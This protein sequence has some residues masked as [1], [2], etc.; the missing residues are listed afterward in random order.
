MYQKSRYLEVNKRDKEY[1]V[2][3]R[4]FG[5]L[6]KL[7][8]NAYQML[9]MAAE[10][11]LDIPDFEGI[12]NKF[13]DNYFLVEDKEEEEILKEEIANRKQAQD[14]R[15]LVGLQLIVSN[16]C[17]FHCTY[18]F[19][20]EEHKLRDNSEA[21]RPSDMNFEVARQSVD[22]MIENLKKNNNKLLSI[23]FFGGEPLMNWSVIKQVFDMYGT[24]EAF[25]IEIYYTIT[26]NGS[27]ITEEIAEY[28]GKY[29][30]SVII[31]Y[32][33]PNSRERVS[34]NGLLLD[35][36]M[37]PVLTTLKDKNVTVS[38]NSV[39]SKWTIGHYDYKG[40]VDFAA[41][42]GIRYLGLILDLDGDFLS[43]GFGESDI[44]KLLLDAYD[45][46]TKKGLHITG[47]WAKMYSQIKNEEGTFFEKGY[48]VC[49]AT[50]SKVSVE[51]SGDIFACKCSPSKMG[52]ID[53]FT[54][55]LEGDKYRSYL[56][57]VYKN[58]SD[59][60][61]CEIQSFCS[62]ICVGTLEKKGS[63]YGNNKSLCQIYKTITKELIL[64][65]DDKDFTDIIEV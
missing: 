49:P 11:T 48:K 40:L 8:E 62:G 24:G 5:N 34:N 17:N 14:G 41:A 37:I 50:G 65:A 47:Y 55:V 21:N 25:G 1:L 16:F 61:D 13:I 35:D 33:S 60:T 63:M 3:H 44:T 9:E 20:N 10:P 56:N 12:R 22:N 59:C 29:N 30:V 18:C 45:Y 6:S 57:K 38:F 23:E 4:L 36:I 28:F 53:A 31:S 46:G 27:Q 15:L 51:P 54:D 43:I 64:R 7:N 32:D 52:S 42:H 19:L 39:I 58:G 26:T 2:Y